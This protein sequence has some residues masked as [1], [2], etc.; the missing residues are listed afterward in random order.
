MCKFMFSHTN[1]VLS[2]YTFNHHYLL[3]CVE[4]HPTQRLH[5]VTSR[6]HSPLP[7]SANGH[8]PGLRKLE[9]VHAGGLG[10]CHHQ[11]SVCAGEISH[12]WIFGSW[13]TGRS[14]YH[15]FI[16]V[17]VLPAKLFG[18]HC[19]IYTCLNPLSTNYLFQALYRVPSIFT[20]L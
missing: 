11:R 17:S 2:T 8:A 6:Q 10:R 14:H 12:A 1:P 16:Q 3:C 9:N 7:T 20:R 4:K 18:A 13:Q 5:F 19:S 15:Q